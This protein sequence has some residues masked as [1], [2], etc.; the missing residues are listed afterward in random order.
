MPGFSAAPGAHG[1]RG[2][3]FGWTETAL[4]LHLAHCDPVTLGSSPNGYL[5]SKTVPSNPQDTGDY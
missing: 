5:F 4:A 3:D 2:H 1:D